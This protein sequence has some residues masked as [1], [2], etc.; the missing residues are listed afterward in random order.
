MKHSREALESAVDDVSEPS[1]QL[2]QKKQ[3]RK[4]SKSGNDRDDE[5]G[6]TKQTEESSEERDS[7]QPDQ[8][9]DKDGCQDSYPY[10]VEADDHCETPLE[11]YKDILP[12]LSSL[13]RHN[14][15]TLADLLVYDPYFCEGSMVERL[16]S[17]GVEKV[18]NKKEDFYAILASRSTPPHDVLITNPPYSQDHMERLFRYVSSSSKPYCLLL[19]NY[20]Y[21]K[22]YVFRSPHISKLFFLVPTTR[23]LY[24]TPKGRR[25]QKSGKF[26]SPFPSFWYCGNFR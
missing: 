6:A 3:K 19:P 23:Y 15:K 1:E 17:L 10:P 12:L 11:A 13:A 16:N 14:Q 7:A 2:Q 26:T 4:K 21:M 22:D 5:R 24:T 18:Y 20:V 9:S 8:P 25:Q